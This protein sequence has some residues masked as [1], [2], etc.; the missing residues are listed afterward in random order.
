M[1]WILE[2]KGLICRELSVL[3]IIINAHRNKSILTQ[4]SSKFCY[5]QWLL[6]WTIMIYARV[7]YI[8]KY[9]TVCTRLQCCPLSFQACYWSHSC[10]RSI[11]IYYTERSIYYRLWLPS[12]TGAEM[13]TKNTR[14]QCD[15]SMSNVLHLCYNCQYTFGHTTCFWSCTSCSACNVTYSY[16]KIAAVWETFATKWF[17]LW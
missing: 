14:Q 15:L 11:K 5:V 2:R 12:K 9:P 6:L 7:I 16:N 8:F 10:E 17:L 13:P 3:I 1:H 4:N